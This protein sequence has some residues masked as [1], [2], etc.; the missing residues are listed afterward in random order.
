MD[1]PSLVDLMPGIQMSAGVFLAL[2][3]ATCVTAGVTGLRTTWLVVGLVLATWISYGVYEYL[4]PQGLRYDLLILV[5]LLLVV[6][7]VG[8]G[9]LLV[10]KRTRRD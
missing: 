2:G 8:F 5:P 4:A 3:I 7:G 9:A 10:R 1:H 6:T